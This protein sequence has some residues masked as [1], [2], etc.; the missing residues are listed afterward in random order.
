MV[1]P[2]TDELLA[3]NPELA[4]KM[5]WTKTE[6]QKM[7]DDPTYRPYH[8]E[9]WLSISHGTENDEGSKIVRFEESDFVHVPEL[10][11]FLTNP[12][13]EIRLNHSTY[14]DETYERYVTSKFL[15]DLKTFIEIDGNYYQLS[16]SVGR[17]TPWDP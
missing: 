14:D 11:E 10:R 16:T 17:V 4:A 3:D 15:S 1:Y 12:K 9:L 6:G 7:I 2:T 5:T 8:W 13:A